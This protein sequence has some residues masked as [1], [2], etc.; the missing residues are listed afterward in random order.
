M[1]AFEPFVQQILIYPTEPILIANETLAA[2]VP[3]VQY[4]DETMGYN[5][6]TSAYYMGIWTKE[7]NIKPVCPSGNCTWPSYKSLGFA[8]NAWISHLL[9][10]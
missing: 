6:W 9:R 7:F 2:A 3:Q 1:L 5:A 4:Y 10:R 8:A